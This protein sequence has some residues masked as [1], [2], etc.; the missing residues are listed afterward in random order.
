M[1]VTIKVGG[2][3]RQKV[4]GLVGGERVLDLE[5]GALLSSI[6]PVIDLDVTEV[7]VI[8][9]NGRPV[10]EDLVLKDGD[11]VGMFPRALA[12]NMYVAINFFNTLVRD[13]L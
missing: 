11:R 5:E 3:L 6:F 1:K 8:M 13:K 12:F 10:G 4:D 9:V 2:P 7:R